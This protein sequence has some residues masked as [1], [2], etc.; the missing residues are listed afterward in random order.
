MLLAQIQ[1]TPSA[2][3][4]ATDMPFIPEKEIVILYFVE[5]GCTYTS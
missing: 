2:Q 4:D 3:V 1:V 5:L